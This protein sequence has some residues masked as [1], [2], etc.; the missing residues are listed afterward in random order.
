MC[1]LS[2]ILFYNKISNV[3]RRDLQNKTPS[4]NN[5]PGYQKNE[6][7]RVI[8]IAY[9]LS[10]RSRVAES[11]ALGSLYLSCD[12]GQSGAGMHAVSPKLGLCRSA[13]GG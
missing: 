1:K 8:L 6:R 12:S 7:N 9:P 4:E 10:G 13:L 11:S 3:A 5:E 2:L